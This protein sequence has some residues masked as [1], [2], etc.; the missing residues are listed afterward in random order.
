MLGRAS[1]K[2]GLAV[3]GLCLIVV[4]AGRA[5]ADPVALD[6][7]G[8]YAATTTFDS[9]RGWEFTVTSPIVIQ[10]LGLWDLG[11]DGL[12]QAHAVGIWGNI[13]T[14]PVLLASTTITNSSFLIGSINPN[15]RWLFN[16]ITSITLNPGRYVVAANYLALPTQDAFMYN[17]NSFTVPEI[18]FG[19]SRVGSGSTLS[20]P[21]V[22]HPELGSACFGPNLL[23]ATPEPATLLLLS[24]GLA[25]VA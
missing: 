20:F 3:A 22:T 25:G 10:G 12:V 6:F 9:N 15:G 17:A 14:S 4:V 11:S 1:R 5:D 23:V 24:T 16:N 7:T 2:F 21:D 18:T 8:G 19:V 13:D